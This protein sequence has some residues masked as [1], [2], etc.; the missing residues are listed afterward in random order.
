MSYVDFSFSKNYEEA[1]NKGL[2]PLSKAEKVLGVDYK[3]LYLFADEWHHTSKHYN[4]TVMISQFKFSEPFLEALQ[5][6]T[7]ENKEFLDRF[8]NK[9]KNGARYGKLNNEFYDFFIDPKNPTPPE[10]CNYILISETLKEEIEKTFEEKR[11]D[12][13]LIPNIGTVGKNQYPINILILDNEIRICFGK[14]PRS[15][16]IKKYYYSDKNELVKIASE[17]ADDLNLNADKIYEKL[18]EKIGVAK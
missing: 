15:N 17:I 16:W 9:P 4:K 10:E 5:K 18:I 6:F 13:V 8:S 3:I 1:I 2:L 7:K 14:T 11:E 12:F